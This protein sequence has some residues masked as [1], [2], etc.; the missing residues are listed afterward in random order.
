M[1]VLSLP[2]DT[3]QTIFYKKIFLMSKINQVPKD[4]QLDHK[5]EKCKV[6]ITNRVKTKFTSVEE[7]GAVMR[8]GTWKSFALADQA[9]E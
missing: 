6:M 4:K 3:P 8:T 7:E 9:L 1:A 2:P 5:I